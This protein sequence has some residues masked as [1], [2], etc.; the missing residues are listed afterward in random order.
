MDNKA[1]EG[2]LREKIAKLMNTYA[3]YVRECG[4]LKKQPE[5]KV[6]DSFADQIL[7]LVSA[8]QQAEIEKARCAICGGEMS[9]NP[10][11]NA[12]LVNVVPDY[13]EIGTKMVCIPCTVKSRHKWAEWAMKADSEIEKARTEL[14]EKVRTVLSNY[15]D[16]NLPS[17]KYYIGGQ[18]V[19]KLIEES[20]EVEVKY[21][22]RNLDQ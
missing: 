19:D 22:S 1:S 6:S 10:H 2:D 4:M 3:Y 17:G 15:G 18:S 7:S 8:H 14:L 20:Q 16:R 9:I 12:G 11:P 5:Q 21:D 13:L